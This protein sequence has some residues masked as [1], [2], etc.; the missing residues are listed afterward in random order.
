M[1]AEQR[2]MMEKMMPSLDKMAE[3]SSRCSAR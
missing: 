2:A 1:P 3:A